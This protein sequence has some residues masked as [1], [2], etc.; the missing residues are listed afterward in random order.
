MDVDATSAKATEAARRSRLD[1]ARSATKDKPFHIKIVLRN[2]TYRI[3]YKAALSAVFRDQA[4]RLKHKNL[5][6]S[7]KG[8][9][10][11]GTDSEKHGSIK[12]CD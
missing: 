4:T 9:S 3:R 1:Q 5:A 7:F 2:T 11:T 6:F 12:H 8:R 10:L